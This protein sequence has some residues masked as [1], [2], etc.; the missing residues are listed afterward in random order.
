MKRTK[1]IRPALCAALLQTG[2]FLPGTSL[3]AE[4][5][6][7][8]D[9]RRLDWIS[10]ADIAAMPPEQ[11]PQHTGMCEG[12]YISPTLDD[13]EPADSR[14]NA[15]SERFDT[16][17]D[18]T[19]LLE[20][21]VLIKQGSRELKS[22]SVR[23]DRNSR[24]SELNGNVVIRQP[25]M[26]IR[27]DSAKINLNEKKLD[28]SGTEYVIHNIHVHGSAGRIH[29]PN[30]RVLILDDSTYTTCE[31]DDNAWRI[32]AGRIKLDQDSGWGQVQDAVVEV[33]GIPVAYLPWWMFPI[34]D[35]RQ[36]GFLF[37][38]ISNNSESGLRLGLPYYLNL[39]PDYDATLTPTLIGDRGTLME[40]EFRYLSE[41]TEGFIGGAYLPADSEYYN[42]DRSLGSWKHLGHYDQLVNTVN[43]TNVS[44]IDY[45]EDLGTGLDTSAATH[46]EQRADLFYY[47]EQWELGALLQQYQTIDETILNNDLPYRKLPQLQANGLFPTAHDPLE[48]T[49]GSEYVYF[50]HPEAGSPT[51]T[52]ADNADRARSAAGVRYNFRRSWGHLVPSYSHRYRYYSIY[53]GPLDQQEPHLA[54]PVFNVDSGLLFDRLFQFR[55]HAFI[56]TL[57]PRLY[58]LYVPYRDQNHL[59]LFD[60]AKNSFGFEQLFRDNRFTGGDRIGDAN[61]VSLGFTSRF[62]DSDGG[63]ER[64]NLGLGQTF[65]L[66]DRQV[67]LFPTDPVDTTDVSP[68]VARSYWMIDTNWS[69]RTET[70]VDTAVNNLD[71]L[72]TGLA[73]RGDEGNVLNLNYNYYDNGAITADPAAEMI[74]QTDLSFMWSVSQRWGI[75]GR[76]GYDLEEDR[77]F[78][79]IVGVEYES[80]CWRA[81]VVN[82]RFLKESN[83]EPDVLEPTQGIYLQVELKGLGGVG[84]TVDSILEEGIAGYREREELR[85]PKF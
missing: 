82:R 13:G 69:W 1:L 48:F 11:R 64:L 78:D 67:Q 58:Y 61:Q 79:N 50:E 46:L 54:V 4:D 70:Q 14:V 7:P 27:G 49:L 76:W 81:R 66:Q 21:D 38:A 29:N 35:R 5:T 74:R 18:G 44:D 12:I 73:Y 40:G 3:H 63:L 9:Y 80:C 52:V 68:Y 65:Y 10:P 41:H 22:D 30:D 77:S 36:S 83:T 34:D 71:T 85:P 23:L 28:V 51:L 53:G 59:P 15:S 42:L 2:F 47:G 19:L 75:I 8:P 45:F 72:V 43:Y 39:A 62:I 84:G 20:G 31:P 26:L 6:A 25:G 56:Q 60:T 37:P 17:A 57:E 16:S 24:E 32:K 55:D 33:K